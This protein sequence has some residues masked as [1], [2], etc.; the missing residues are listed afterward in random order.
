MED[1][2]SVPRE[3][4]GWAGLCQIEGEL[5]TPC[6][7]VDL[8]MSGLG[9][10]LSH[11]SFPRRDRGATVGDTLPQ[12]VGRRIS[13]DVPA[14]G[15]S[16]SIRLEGQVANARRMSGVLFASAS[17]SIVCPNLFGVPRCSAR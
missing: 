7:V 1:R 14:L 6:R 15:D 12:L 3:R 5:A 8:S 4:V 13:V 11:T 17:S 2:R 16:L 10:T 9:V